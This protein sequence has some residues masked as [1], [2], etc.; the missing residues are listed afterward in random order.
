MLVGQLG[1]FSGNK[2]L[3]LWGNHWLIPLTDSFEWFNSDSIWNTPGELFAQLNHSKILIVQLQTIVDHLT[4]QLNQ[5]DW[6]IQ[7]RY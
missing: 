3:S 1:A 2:W 5:L 6:F 4:N 7:E